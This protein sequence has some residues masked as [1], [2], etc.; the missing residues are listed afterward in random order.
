MRSS[1]DPS[2]QGEDENIF[3]NPYVLGNTRWNVLLNQNGP[4]C[5][6]RLWIT[7]HA[8]GRLRIYFDE[9]PYPRID[10]TISEFFSGSYKH[11]KPLSCFV[12][13]GIRRGPCQLF[14]S[15]F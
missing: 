8:E 1:H 7:G 11:F 13:D 2:D 6:T 5:V 15:S 12:A 4:G 10:T 3:D 9:D 14:S